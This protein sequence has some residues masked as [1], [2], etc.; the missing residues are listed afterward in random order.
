MSAVG[1]PNH[2]CIG[3]KFTKANDFIVRNGSI[4]SKKFIYCVCTCKELLKDL[5]ETLKL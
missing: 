3:D 2:V 5:E 1:W 4:V